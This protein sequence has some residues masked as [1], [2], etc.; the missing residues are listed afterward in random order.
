[1]G[2][3]SSSNLSC[4]LLLVSRGQMNGFRKD[5]HAMY[6]HFGVVSAATPLP[7]LSLS[8][9]L[10]FRY[11][12]R[13]DFHRFLHFA[14]AEKQRLVKPCGSALCSSNW[15]GFKRGEILIVLNRDLKSHRLTVRHMHTLHFSTL[16][17]THECAHTY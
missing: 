6:F 14:S 16:K 1:M 17:H 5:R 7:F 15:A 11:V 2:A 4:R 3:C 12:S 8:F 9:L 13:R 10:A